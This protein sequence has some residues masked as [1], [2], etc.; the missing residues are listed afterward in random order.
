MK[1]STLLKQY[2]YDTNQLSKDVTNVK[3]YESLLQALAEQL[4]GQI[5]K[6]MNKY[7]K[8]YNKKLK[9]DNGKVY[10]PSDFIK[11]VAREVQDTI[12]RLV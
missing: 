6:I 2:G 5:E 10:N 3:A 7:I 12:Q 9:L 8:L 1:L 4:N 11:K